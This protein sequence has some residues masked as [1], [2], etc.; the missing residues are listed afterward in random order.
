[1]LAGLTGNFGTGKST[2]LGLF[3]ALGAVTVSADEIV[4]RL[5]G[6]DAIKGELVAVAGDIL[7]Q[8]GEIDK[9]KM[10]GVV[11]SDAA[12]RARVEAII[13]PHVMREIKELHERNAGAIVVAEIPL[14]FEGGFERDVDVTITVVST[15]EAINQR[16]IR[17]GYSHQEAERRLAAQMSDSKKV[18][19]STYVIDNSST[20]DVLQRQ[21]EAV[22]ESLTASESPAEVR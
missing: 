9:R 22:S 7:T 19:M 4:H 14:L 6:L 21:V 12:I 8:D 13:H 11:F 15:S 18:Q 3:S 10:A 2:V 5:L 16:L 17:K 20:L 1:M